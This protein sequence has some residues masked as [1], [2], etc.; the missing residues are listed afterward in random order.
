M[1][2]FDEVKLNEV[3]DFICDHH[4]K[5]RCSPTYREIS[6]A[7]DISSTSWV[8]NLVNVLAKRG[9]IELEKRGNKHVISIP[10]NLSVGT[11]RNASIVGSCPCGAPVL[12]VENI[13]STVA[14]PTEI[15]GDSEHI[16]LK[17]SGN[18][19]IKR[20]IFDGDLM[21][22]KVQDTAN[23]GD[24]VIARVNNE[25]ATAKVLAF[26]N[27]RYYLKPANDARNKSGELIYKDIYP[28]DEWD[29]IGVVDHVIHSPIREVI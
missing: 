4:K 28:D 24:V 2:R 18:S 14:L 1:R 9:Q 11:T 21:V 17:A 25:E 15:F 13:I 7:C 23:V 20:G 5:Q 19:M 29:I 22:V 8:S 16:I 10:D 6:R 26:K 27:D 3:Y 12:A